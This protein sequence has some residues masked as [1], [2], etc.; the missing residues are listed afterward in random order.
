[1]VFLPQSDDLRSKCEWAIEKALESKGLRFLG[2]R[3]VPVEPDEIGKMAR[4]IMPRIR[5]CF[6]ESPEDLAGDDLERRLYVARKAAERTVAELATSETERAL[7]GQFY[8]CSLSSR[9][10]VYK[11]LLMAKQ[12]RSFYPE[13]DDDRMKSVFAMSILA[14]A[15][16]RLAHGSWLIPIAS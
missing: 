12:L 9:T 3:D 4:H 10:I 16:T 5:Q 14:S 6:A 13:L 1:M 7:S 11:G 2:W 15:R 8:I